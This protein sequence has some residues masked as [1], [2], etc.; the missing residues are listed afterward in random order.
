MVPKEHFTQTRTVCFGETQFGRSPQCF[1]LLS[2]D[3]CDLFNKAVGYWQTLNGHFE[4]EVFFSYI[5][6]TALYCALMRNWTFSSVILMVTN[7]TGL[8]VS[9]SELP[10]VLMP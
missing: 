9:H 3:P 6:A 1:A 7:G 5:E 10:E 4:L 8:V 2:G